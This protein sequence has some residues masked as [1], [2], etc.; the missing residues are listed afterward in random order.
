MDRTKIRKRKGDGRVLRRG[1][2]D[3]D[4]LDRHLR[5]VQDHRHY[6][7]H[8]CGGCAFATGLGGLIETKVMEKAGKIMVTLPDLELDA[9]LRVDDLDTEMR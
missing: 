9:T 1:L 5:A 2:G 6:R 7:I 3:F 8:L 4:V